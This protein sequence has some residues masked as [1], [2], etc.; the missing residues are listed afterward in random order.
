MQ[1]EALVREPGGSRRVLDDIKDFVGWGGI[2]AL[3]ETCM[4]TPYY[5][6]PNSIFEDEVREALRQKLRVRDRAL[7]S[8]LFLFGGRVSEVL[9]ARKRNIIVE[10]EFILVDRLPVLK[11]YT[12]V[13]TEVNRLY[14]FPTPDDVGYVWDPQKV[15]FIK[16]ERS[17]LPKVEER[18]L[19]PIPRWEPLTDIL[20]EYVSDVDDWLF[21]SNYEIKREETSGV[22]KWV[23]EKYLLKNGTRAWISPQRA[24]QIVTKASK[25]VGLTFS[26]DNVAAKGIWNHWFRAQR[27]TQLGRDYQFDDAYKNRYFS[28]SQPRDATTASL[29]SRVGEMQLEEQ[30]NENRDR[31]T[32]MLKRDF[33]RWKN[34]MSNN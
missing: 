28:W 9:M 10:D 29:Y 6:R 8:A 23:D 24:W 13:K 17:T 14:S 1:W 15:C 31:H 11:R 33:T 7:V 3:A 19:F 20:L 2:V 34:D 4:E 27:T 12:R 25:K 26:K 16:Y 5:S 30:M 22:Q 32:R 21:P 18:K